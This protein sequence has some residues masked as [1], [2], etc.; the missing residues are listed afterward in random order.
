MTNHP[1]SPPLPCCDATLDDLAV[2]VRVSGIDVLGL[3]EVVQVKRHG[4]QAV[5]LTYRTGDGEVGEQMLFRSDEGSFA[6]IDDEISPA[7]RFD[8]DGN[9]QLAA[10]GTANQ[11]ARRTHQ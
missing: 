9:L 4:T 7:W 3:V 8:G 5:T 6:I 10:R 11:R 2:G 1:P